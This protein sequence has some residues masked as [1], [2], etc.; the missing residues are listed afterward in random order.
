MRRNRIVFLLLI[1]VSI[2][3]LYNRSGKIAFLLF[4]S[5]LSLL[6]VSIGYAYYVFLRF[7]YVQKIDKTVITKGDKVHLNMLMCNEDF[8]AYPFIHISFFGNSLLNYKDLNHNL[9]LKPR[10]KVDVNLELEFKYRGEYEI[11]INKFYVE[12]F[13]GL[14]RFRYRILETKKIIVNPRIIFFDKFNLIPEYTADMNAGT[15]GRFED[16]TSIKDIRKYEYGD[17]CK[18]IHWK[19]S[20]K[21]NT[22]LVKNFQCLT[23]ENISIILDYGK[24]TYDN[25]TNSMIE[26]T[27]VE[28][29]IS[30]IY[31]YVNRAIPVNLIEFRNKLELIPVSSFSQFN[32]VYKYLATVNF[33][34]TIPVENILELY[35]FSENKLKDTI[36]IT[37]HLTVDLY[38]SIFNT[39]MAGGD[40][41]V[42]CVTGDKEDIQATKDIKMIIDSLFDIGVNAYILYP[43][44]DIKQALGA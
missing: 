37:S 8:I 36:I 15:D 26:D 21:K 17:S 25:E 28:A 32:S 10:S 14:I 19:L 4:N 44:C 30:L 7:K 1:I 22:L 24:N 43:G 3:F 9:F 11:G 13:L 35:S 16:T 29:T 5:L 33:Q 41:C 39:K 20:A 38:N 18:R 40:I 23:S 34:Q 12:D 27:L 6:L 42:I 31:Y 2:V